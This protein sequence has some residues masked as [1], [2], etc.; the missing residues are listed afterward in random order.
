MPTDQSAP[1]DKIDTRNYGVTYRAIGFITDP[2]PDYPGDWICIEDFFGTQRDGQWAG[3][4]WNFSAFYSPS[5][6]ETHFLGDWADCP[7]L[8][9]NSQP[10][11]AQVKAHARQYAQKE[12]ECAKAEADAKIKE[13]KR[14]EEFAARELNHKTNGVPWANVLL[15]GPGFHKPICE[16]V[17]WLSTLD[18]LK[19]AVDSYIKDS[20]PPDTT[21]TSIELTKRPYD[22]YV[23]F[24]DNAWKK[25]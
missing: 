16:P 17:P 21:C 1:T 4:Q 23:T 5:R 15:V 12:I 8:K 14:D 20:C 18:E 6:K 11:E 7:I 9:T 25:M 24:R 19:T 13:K 2:L 10:T 22:E 3:E